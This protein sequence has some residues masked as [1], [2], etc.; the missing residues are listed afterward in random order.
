MDVGLVKDISV[1]LPNI[2]EQ[3]CSGMIRV[4]ISGIGRWPLIVLVVL[5]WRGS[6]PTCVGLSRLQPRAFSKS[7]GK[8]LLPSCMLKCRSVTWGLC[9]F[10]LFEYLRL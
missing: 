7:L 9:C 8:G 3:A 5:P 2:P 10:R 4:L 6:R 1:A